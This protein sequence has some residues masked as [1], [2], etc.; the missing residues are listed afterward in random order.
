[1]ASQRFFPAKHTTQLFVLKRNGLFLTQDRLNPYNLVKYHSSGDLHVISHQDKGLVRPLF[2]KPYVKRDLQG[3][4]HLTK[5]LMWTRMKSGQFAVH[6]TRFG[7]QIGELIHGT[8]IAQKYPKAFTWLYNSTDTEVSTLNSKYVKCYALSVICQLTLAT[9]IE[10][11]ADYFTKSFLQGLSAHLNRYRVDR[12][13]ASDR[14]SQIQAAARVTWSQSRS[15]AAE[16]AQAS[17]G[18]STGQDAG[19]K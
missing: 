3:S 14:G 18:E 2:N 8:C 10:W 19:E 16:L 1:M 6:L 9:N 12:I 17:G 11:L 13:V 5:S 7:E 15:A 4:M